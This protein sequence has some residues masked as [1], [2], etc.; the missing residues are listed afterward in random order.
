MRLTVLVDNSAI[1]DRYYL[2][3]PGFS[4]LLDD[5]DTRILFDAGYSAAFLDNA[6]AM[7]LELGGIDAVVLSHGHDDHAGGL[8]HWLERGPTAAAGGGPAL[9][10]H[11]RAFDPKRSGGLDIGSP[12]SLA[13]LSGRFE[14]RLSREPLRV[15]PRF[16]FLGEIP[17]RNDV[18]AREPIGETDGPE[19]TVPDY[20]LDDSAIA[21][22]GDDGIVVVTGCSHS[23][24]VNVVEH[25]VRVCGDDRVVDVV[26]GFHLLG[27]SVAR[28]DFTARRLGA[29]APKAIHPCHCTDLA[30][31]IRLA[32]DLPVRDLGVGL[33]L[34][35]R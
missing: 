13:E 9:I 10:A 17:R 7:G 32:A 21:W 1:I 14:P 23:G 27:A 31:K 12:A 6:G 3:E 2:A 35:Y 34:E 4:C 25:A 8:R 30:A 15:G 16:V 18:E 26:G 5:G 29:L 33:E 24:V 11:P 28:L 19:G 20:L 22:K